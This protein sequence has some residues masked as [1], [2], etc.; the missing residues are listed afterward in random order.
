[1]DKSLWSPQL[2]YPSN[3]SQ[4]LTP[5]LA[6]HSHIHD[7]SR[8]IHNQILALRIAGDNLVQHLGGLE[9]AVFAETEVWEDRAGRGGGKVTR[10]GSKDVDGSSDEEDGEEY[11]SLDEEND[12]E[13][14]EEDGSWSWKTFIE[15]QLARERR[16][17]GLPPESFDPA[18]GPAADGQHGRRIPS[19][20]DD[21]LP[22]TVAV[23]G[24]SGIE[25]DMEIINKIPVLACFLPA[26]SSSSKNKGKDKERNGDAAETASNKADG[27]WSGKMLGDFVNPGKMRTVSE[28]CK[29]IY[30][31][32]Q[33]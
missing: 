4:P 14:E 9:D 33:A 13:V 11:V 30:G 20:G 15:K 32:R 1:M 2:A 24:R 27:K 28:S 19:A 29:R 10:R 17:L 23:A 25:R 18:G 3:T 31:E 26:T 6:N 16:L 12:G 7:L 8:R 5:I 21:V 22:A